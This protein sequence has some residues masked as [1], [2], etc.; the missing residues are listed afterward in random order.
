M[1][2]PASAS[3]STGTSTETSVE[4]STATSTEPV[5][6]APKPAVLHG[7]TAL[8]TGASRGIGRAIAERLARDG[9]LVAVH[10]GASRAAADATVAAITAAGGQAFAIGADVRSVDAIKTMFTE[11][12][13]ALN[14]RTGAARL[15]I[16]VNNAGV[17]AGFGPI[18]ATT[19]ATFDNLFDTNFKGLFFM[20]QQAL[21]RLRDG[22]HVVNISSLSSRG[23]HPMLAAYA[24]SKIPINSFTQALAV[25]L[26]PR[27]IAVNAVLPGL[28]LTDLT[29]HLQQNPALLESSVKTVAFGRAALPV[30]IANVVGA[31]V[32]GDLNW[33]TGQLLEATG[34]A[35]L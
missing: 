20:T 33:I 12:D 35:R 29:E 1:S 25:E 15:D 28:V 4:T 6:A 24:A 31:L 7:K 34:G 19:E 14:A 27:Q 9:A 32:G 26:G 3:V 8:V 17:G 5:T 30:D 13:T 18:A 11:L 10:Y 16:L 21:P 23:G 2:T 22:G